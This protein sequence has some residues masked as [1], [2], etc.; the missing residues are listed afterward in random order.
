MKNTNKNQ[1]LVDVDLNKVD[2]IALDSYNHIE[3][4]YPIVERGNNALLW[5]E[6]IKGG[7]DLEDLYNVTEVPRNPTTPM[8]SIEPIR[9]RK[10]TPE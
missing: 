8:E 2:D 3:M 5:P 10:Y 9:K 7:I 4:G 1:H 6:E